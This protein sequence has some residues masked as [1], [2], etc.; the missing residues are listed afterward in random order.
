[1]VYDHACSLGYAAGIYVRRRRD[2]V[3]QAAGRSPAMAWREIYSY[4][5]HP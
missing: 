4:T 3:A 2:A 5:I 1:M